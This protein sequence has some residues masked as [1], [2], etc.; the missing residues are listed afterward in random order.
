M[1]SFWIRH[2]ISLLYFLG[3][4]LLIALSNLRSWRRLSRYGRPPA[5]PAPRVSVLIPARN[6]EA[7]VLPCV[8]SL[9]AQD[10]P[11]YEVLVLDDESADGTADVLMSLPAD[12]RL[13]LL[14]GDP[15]PAGWLGKN[16]ACDQLARTATG[17]LLLFVDADTRHEPPALTHA[18]A[19]L[20]EEQAD[21]VSVFP[22]QE[23]G[24]WGE[25]LVVPILQWSLSSFLPLG[26]AYQVRWSRFSASSGQFLLFRRRAYELVGGHAAVRRSVVEDVALTRAIG[27]AGLRWRLL[28]GQPY[29][30]CRMY[31]NFRQVYD[32]L[33]KNLFAIFGYNVPLFLFIW[34]YLLLVF[35]EPLVVFA[36]AALGRMGPPSVT[37]ALRNVALSLTLWGFTCWRFGFPLYLAL[38]YP[39]TILLTVILAMRSMWLT[40]LGRTAW[41]GRPLARS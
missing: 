36:L 2:Q 38:L 37:I 3:V 19:A 40:L 24:S 34:L 4:L 28:D 23:V 6:E 33:S 16:W 25:R 9:L 7:N 1:S 10:Y 22:R 31:H 30:R 26:L 14:Q 12:P 5:Q 39:L 29:I 20:Q 11:D 13:T 41:K 17:D 27:A 35:W 21:L 32:G 15:L 18:V 8:R